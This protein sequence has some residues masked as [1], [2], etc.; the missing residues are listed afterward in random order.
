M[1]RY[2]YMNI[3]LPDAQRRREQRAWYWYDFGNSAYAAVVLLAIYSA[4]FK[5]TVVGGAEGTR[6]WG[7]AVG[8]AMLVVAVTSPIFGAIADFSASKKR[9]LFFFSALTWVFTALLFFVRQGDIWMGMLFFVLAEIGYRS[10]QVFYNAMLPEVAAPDEIAR[11]SG[12]GWALGALGGIL[13]LVMILP[14]ILIFKEAGDLPVRASFVFTAVFFLLASLPL[15][16][17]VPERSNSQKLPE[18]GSYLTVGFQRVFR[19]LR[20]LRHFR[21]FARFIVAYLVYNDGILMALNFAAIIGAV[22]FGM[23]QTQLILFMILVQA[24]SVFGAWWF[25]ILGERYGFRRALVWALWLMVLAVVAMLATQTIWQFY[26]VGA[27]AGLALTGVQSLSRALISVLAPKGQSAEFYG[28][29]SIAGRTSSFIGPTIYGL[30]AAG[31]ARYF[32]QQGYTALL[33]EQAG[34]RVAIVSIIVFLLVGLFLLLRVDEAAGRQEAM[35]AAEQI[36]AA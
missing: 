2:A 15:L 28:F 31:A 6:L 14:P 16:R 26:L 20:K 35:A 34:Q 30:L 21:Q 17:S 24:S 29:F 10:A 22:L 7:I 36:D 32:E 4:Y 9:F 5:G 12:N 3:H 27:L 33:A 11:V 1:T 8:I 23:D 25:G 19:T 18:N 13:C